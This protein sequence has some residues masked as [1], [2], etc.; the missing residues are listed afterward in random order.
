VRISLAVIL[1][2]LVTGCISSDIHPDYR[3]VERVSVY[4]TTCYEPYVLSRGCHEDEENPNKKHIVAARIP[5]DVAGQKIKIAATED[6]K[7]IYIGFLGMEGF[8]RSYGEGW[9][10]GAVDYKRDRLNLIVEIMRDRLT[11][12]GAQFVDVV[13]VTN[14]SQIS[15]YY[16]SSDL[17]TYSHAVR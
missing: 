15:G 11:K 17:D 9:T 8:A 6:G 3:N 12:S 2:L 1:V 13:P 7:T 14:I 4:S 5:V 16:I 10:F